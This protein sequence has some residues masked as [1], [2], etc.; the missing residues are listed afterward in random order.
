MKVFISY[1]RQDSAAWAGRLFDALSSRYGTQQIFLDAANVR[2]GEDWRRYI[3]D[4]LAA[5]DAVLAVIGPHWLEAGYRDEGSRRIDDRDDLVRSQLRTALELNKMLVPVL[6]GG[7]TM[8]TRDMLPTDIQSLAR[9][10]SAS[11][12]DTTWNEDVGRLTTVL[13]RLQ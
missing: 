5:S 7:A 11:L 3:E 2:V 1:R 8:P 13:D 12:G 9:Y 10:Q 6:V 4:A